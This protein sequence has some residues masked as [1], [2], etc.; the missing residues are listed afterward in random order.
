MIK[1]IILLVMPLIASSCS[2]AHD[3]HFYSLHPSELQKVIE[4]CPDQHPAGV[5]CEQ[6]SHC[7]RRANVLVSELQYDT[8][9]FGQK[10]LVLQETLATLE[11]SLKTTP[12]Q[13]QLTSSIEKNKTELTER[14]A[15][16]KWLESPRG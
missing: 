13:T 5:T 6:L 8:Q 9:G 2:A 12:N 11:A 7:A 15:I 1:Y 16:V 10:I 3:E 14:L 4:Q